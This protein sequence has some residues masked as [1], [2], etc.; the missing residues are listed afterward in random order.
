MLRVNADGKIQSV[1]ISN[2]GSGYSFGTLD[3]DGAGIT[4]SASSTDAVTSIVIPPSGGHG[5][6]VYEGTWN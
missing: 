5:S 3:L 2:G 4:N 6:D 1:D